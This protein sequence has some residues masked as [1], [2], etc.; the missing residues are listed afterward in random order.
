MI[1]ARD[2][3]Q[4]AREDS[5]ASSPFFL[6]SGG[7]QDGKPL[8]P[9]NRM[10]KKRQLSLSASRAKLEPLSP[11]VPQSWLQSAPEESSGDEPRVV[12][13]QPLREETRG[14][15]RTR[16]V[17]LVRSGNAGSSS[18]KEEPRPVRP[19]SRERSRSPRR[20]HPSK[21]AE[22]EGR[23]ENCTVCRM[24]LLPGD[25][26]Y[27][28]YLPQHESCGKDSRAERDYMRSHAEAS[29]ESSQSK[30]MPFKSSHLSQVS[31]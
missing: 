6:Q 14:R 28:G 11:P 7:D 27:R 19:R 25:A 16:S 10:R 2:L 5:Q 26:R 22:I 20:R 4:L 24:P 18:Q 9:S 8:V 15:A 29:V 13:R 1:S 23:D 3:R 17:E 21:R 31:H 30:L 12:F